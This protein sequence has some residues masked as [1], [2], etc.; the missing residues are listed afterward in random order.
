LTRLDWLAAAG[1]PGMTDERPFRLA[2]PDRAVPGVLWLPASSSP[3]PLVLLGHGGSGHKRSERLLQLARWF[4]A[5]AGIAAV[6]IDGPYHG[7]RVS[8]SLSAV[9]YRQ[10]I[11]SAGAVTVIDRM[12]EDWQLTIQALIAA[13]LVDGERLGYLG[14]SMGTRFGLPLAASLGERLRCLVIGKF[15]L[16]Q[17]EMV[18]PRPDSRLEVAERLARAARAVTM[19]TLFH[20]QWHDEIF[21]RSGQLGLFDLLGSA[22]KRLN[23]YPGRH[24]TT[25]AE[26]I[27]CWQGFVARHL[28]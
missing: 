12:V 19:P 14:M 3:L 16:E 27:E 2:G 6:A 7:D 11:A 10:L 21:P 8:A 17:A 13:R 26:A 18:D 9:Q 20:L 28:R 24:R 5:E 4:T 1:T 23:A 15:G 22:D 25:P